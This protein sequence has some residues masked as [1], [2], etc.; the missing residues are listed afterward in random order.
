ML[1]RLKPAAVALVF[2]LAACAPLGELTSQLGLDPTPLTLTDPLSL[3]TRGKLARETA[4]PLACRA[5]LDAQGVAFAPVADRDE[6]E[7][8]QVRGAGNLGEALGGATVRLSPRRPM[9]TCPLAAAVAVWRA[10]SVEPAARELLGAGVSGLD[11]YGVYA[12]RRVNNAETGQPSGHARAEAIDIAAFR[13]SNGRVVSVERDW[14]KS[15]AEAAFLRRVRD[16]ACRVF[17]ETLS[18]DYNAAHAN[19]LH[20]QVGGPRVCG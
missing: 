3:S 20:L 16:D 11:H 5:W 9:M 1:R 8:C 13:L 19:H 7:F 4:D 17:G 18:P 6:G 10:Q 2:A 12:C 14:L 15:G